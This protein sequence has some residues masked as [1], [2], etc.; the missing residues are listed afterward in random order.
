MQSSWGGR[1]KLGRATFD[2]A[3]RRLINRFDD[4][5]AYLNQLE[6]AA[7]RWLLVMPSAVSFH[8]HGHVPLLRAVQLLLAEDLALVSIWSPTFLPAL[9]AP[10]DRWAER[11]RRD[12]HDG[13][14][15][16]P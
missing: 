11:L 4:D 3:Y 12:L 2:E 6:Q 5:A 9:L 13:T 16:P 10:L 8:G 7:L 15:R 14:L 1:E